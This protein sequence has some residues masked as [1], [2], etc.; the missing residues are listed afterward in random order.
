L[1][2]NLRLEVK[3]EQKRPKVS[4]KD[5]KSPKIGLTYHYRI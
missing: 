4:S 1:L 5:S 3:L 2:H